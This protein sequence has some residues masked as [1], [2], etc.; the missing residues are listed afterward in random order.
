MA[1]KRPP[2]PRRRGNPRVPSETALAAWMDRPAAPSTAAIAAHLGVATVT[3]LNYR[4]GIYLPSLAVAT[5]LAALSGG[6]VPV[7][8]WTE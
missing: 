6:A 2:P 7:E 5:K 4:R 1:R 8:S 3:V